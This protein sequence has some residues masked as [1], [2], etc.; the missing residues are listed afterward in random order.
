MP[1]HGFRQ[2]K[3]RHI[4]CDDPKQDMC[5]TGF[6][7]SSAAGDQNFVQASAKYFALPLRGG[8]G[9]VGVFDLEQPGK[10]KPAACPMLV[11]HSGAVI[12]LDFNPFD[13][14]MLATG[15]EDTFVKLWHIPDG[16][17]TWNDSDERKMHSESLVTLEG[18]RKK[19]IL[20]KFHPTANHV[21]CSASSDGPVK[22][23]D[24]Q[25]ACAIVSYDDMPDHAQDIVF[26]CHGDKIAAS[27]RDKSVRILD[28]RSCSAVSVI[29]N[30]HDGI[31]TV[32]L[33]YVMNDSKLLTFG[34]SKVSA[35]EIK[36]WDL[37][38]LS[39]PLH[40]QKIDNGAGAFFPLLDSDTGVLYLCGKGDGN[41]RLYE[42]EDK[43]PY[44][45]PLG[46]GY[47]STISTRGVCMVP[48]RAM[49]VMSHETTRLL[50][51][52]NNDGVFPLSMTVPRK[53]ESFQDDIFPD[54]AASTPAHTADEWL[55]GSSKTPVTMSLNPKDR[56]N[57]TNNSSGKEFKLV[58]VQSVTKE[59]NE[60]KDRITYL[61]EKLKEQSIDF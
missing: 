55:S 37:S 54:C 40:V 11:G 60:A 3:Y 30:A 14:S 58:T 16:F 43:E 5:W 45:F 19:V 39:K 52:T 7:I 32:K 22:I 26:D 4:F 21:L 44:L 29:P 28:A 8:G 6:R 13:D 35:R 50:K 61:E 1:F 59:L 53:S 46:N 2:S 34:T 36:V 48:K 49:N 38:N 33:S 17:A 10:F 23:W 51:V 56:S 31:R 25:K 12:D 18:H 57:E 20:V 27:C 15:S 9:P 47:R 42:F 24:I 41:I